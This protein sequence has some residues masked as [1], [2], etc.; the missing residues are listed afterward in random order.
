MDL[1][2]GVVPDWINRR[3]RYRASRQRAAGPSESLNNLGILL[4]VTFLFSIVVSVKRRRDERLNRIRANWGRPADHP[5]QFSALAESHISRISASAGTRSLDDRTWADLDLDKVFAAIDRTTST[6][7]Q[8]ALYHRLRTA[9]VGKH[10]EAFEVLTERLRGDAPA[11]ERA[12][13]ALDRLQDPQGYNVWWLGQPDA[14][15]GRWWFAI[16]PVLTAAALVSMALLPVSPALCDRD[17]AREHA[18]A[19]SHRSPDWGDR[20]E[21]QAVRAVDWNGGGADVHRRR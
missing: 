21:H 13:I 3:R 17:A 7:G 11:R 20:R 2:P 4:A 8:Q 12:Q 1:G 14:V 19:L 9:P 10:L 5:R 6:L 15:E 16:F 18:D